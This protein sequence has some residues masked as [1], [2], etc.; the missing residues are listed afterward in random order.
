[1][2]KCENR[3][4]C[5]VRNIETASEIAESE[6]PQDN[7]KTLKNSEMLESDQIRKI[8]N[9]KCLH[10]KKCINSTSLIRMRL[11]NL[12][13]ASQETN[14]LYCC[15]NNFIVNFHKCYWIEK[16]CSN[17]LMLSMQHSIF[18]MYLEGIY[19]KKITTEFFNWEIDRH[20]PAIYYT[21]FFICAIYIFWE[22]KC[23]IKKFIISSEIC[24][25]LNFLECII[26]LKTEFIRNDSENIVI[27]N[28]VLL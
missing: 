27:R 26:S 13:V 11:L 1:M 15:F 20:C 5:F 6:Y 22:M 16:I 24:Y 8:R 17:Q 28:Y 25:F 7:S 23:V 12:I 2:Q 18:S 9:I 14:M 21:F 4:E 3:A 10:E 19:R